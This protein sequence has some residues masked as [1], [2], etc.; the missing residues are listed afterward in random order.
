MRHDRIM[1][2]N[3][4]LLISC[5]ATPIFGWSNVFN[6]EGITVQIRKPKNSPI[7]E[8]RATAIFPVS[9]AKF[10]FIMEDM[11]SKC[12]KWMEEC[13]VRRVAKQINAQEKYYYTYFKMPF[14]FQNRDMIIHFR[15]RQDLVKKRILVTLRGRPKFL[16]KRKGITRIRHVKGHWQIDRLASSKIKVTY[17]M[18]MNPGG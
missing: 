9:A 6:K 5:L 11:Y 3:R 14:P 12:Q 4:I 8:F 18:H 17:Q 16:K 10:V 7:K 15:L 2:W 1:M 13:M